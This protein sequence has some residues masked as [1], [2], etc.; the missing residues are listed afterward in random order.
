MILMQLVVWGDACV[1]AFTF[2]L[3]CLK[4]IYMIILFLQY[5]KSFFLSL[6]YI[7]TIYEKLFL[8]YILILLVRKYLS[9]AKR[10]LSQVKSH[11]I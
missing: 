3:P 10:E 4:S 5:M 11:R 2:R 8:I 1:C 6:N 7:F 9:R